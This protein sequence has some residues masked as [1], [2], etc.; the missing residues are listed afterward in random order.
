VG[1]HGLG[2]VRPD[3]AVAGLRGAAIALAREA[4]YLNHPRIRLHLAGEPVDV[5]HLMAPEAVG[6][7][8]RHHPPRSGSG[9]ALLGQVVHHLD[10]AI[11]PL[12]VVTTPDQLLHRIVPIGHPGGRGVEAVV[13]KVAAGGHLIRPERPP[14]V[15]ALAEADEQVAVPRLGPAG[16]DPLLRRCDPRAAAGPG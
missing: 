7:D 13:L 2:L 16:R 8:H 9:D 3:A 11:E 4:T 12:A 1:Q 14:E 6:G 5:P 15:A 10:H